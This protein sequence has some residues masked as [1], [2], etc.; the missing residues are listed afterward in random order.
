[1]DESSILPRSVILI[2]LLGLSGFFAACEAAFFSL[3]TAQVASL[4]DQH[5]RTGTLVSD[6]L[7]T[8]RELLI[9]I[10]IGNELVNI[11]VSALATSIA[12]T[13]FGDVGV[14]IA[15][16]IGTFLILLFGEI[17]PK[18]M[19]LNFAERFALLAAF[20]LKVFAYLVQPIQKPFVRFA[21][22]VITYLGVP[23]FEEEGIITD[24]DF[25]AMVKI[26]EG[27]GIIDAEE[28]ELIHNVIEFGQKTVG[29]IMTPKIDMFYITVNQKMD[30]I[31]PQIIENFYSRVPVF[32]EDEETLVGVLLTKDLANYR[33]LPPEKFNL[34]NIA[35]PALTV[36]AS[37][38][39]K[40]MLK[41]FRKSQ[42]H[43][44]IVLDEYGSIDG[45]VTLEDVLEELV[46][47][48]DSEMRREESFIHKITEKRYRLNAMLSIEEFNNYFTASL[49]D[50]QFNTI[51]G[52]V[53]GLFGR[54][55][56]SAETISFER[57]KFRVEKM[58]GARILSLHLTVTA[59]KKP[60]PNMV[61]EEAAG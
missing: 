38:N 39:L 41:N 25:R 21:Q 27:E 10:Y 53:F 3:N 13:I 36:P 17:L 32:E 9:T 46:G 23:T 43:M 16:G 59:A 22:K 37:K 49:P 2:T 20:P 42:R 26:G 6:L 29:E 18:S 54:V 8:P 45:L 5:G 33:Q 47:E 28:G 52:F 11:G 15:I 35:K 19:A 30:E 1:M 55:P 40:D 44:A 51:G 57:F 50:E 58:K 31:L 34:K 60:E 48:I 12:L 4:K 14:A 61:E 56:R 7:Q 24:A